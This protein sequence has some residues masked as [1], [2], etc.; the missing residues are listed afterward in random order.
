[1]RRISLFLT[2]IVAALLCTTTISCEPADIDNGTTEQPEAPEQPEQPEDP[3]EPEQPEVQQNPDSLAFFNGKRREFKLNK[4]VCYIVE[5]TIFEAPQNISVITFSPEDFTVRPVLPEEVTTVGDVAVANE[6]E[7]AINGCY[8]QVSAG[9]PAGYLKIGGV[10]LATTV[11]AY[12]PRI[13]GLLYMYD[14]RIEFATTTLDDYPNYVGWVEQCDNILACGPM[15]LDDGVEIDYDFV[16]NSDD[17]YMASRKDFYTL[18]H[19]RS[20]IGRDAEG[21]IYLVVVDGRFT[22][23][24]EG[25]SILELADLCSWIGMTEAMNLDGGGS[26]TLWCSKFG[27][28]NHPSDNKIFDHE[29]SRKVLTSIIAKEK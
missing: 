9:T 24:A 23:Q 3:E 7:Y 19:P 22:G 25:M 5:A 1:M 29:G 6:A 20:V 26:S 21:N 13:N 14:D 27:V 15:L 12:Y 4:A 28:V 16:I 18:R 11:S 10:E 2:L 8:W 17:E